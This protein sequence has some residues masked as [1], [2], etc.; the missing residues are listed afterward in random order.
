[1][2]ESTLRTKH[3]NKGFTLIEG[4][5]A[6]AIASI[7]LLFIFSFIGMNLDIHIKSQF[8]LEDSSI[9]NALGDELRKEKSKGCD[10]RGIVQ[11]LQEKYPE[12]TLIEYYETEIENLWM[13]KLK[14]EDQ[15][16][17]YIAYYGGN[18]E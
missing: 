7:G 11:F 13:F 6:I 16:N 12:F 3:L 4:I 1:M 10:D 2:E 14:N 9:L 15:K 17:Y 8:L 18:N 5:L